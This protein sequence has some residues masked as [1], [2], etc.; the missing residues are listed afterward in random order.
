MH[1]AS[2]CAMMP[3]YLLHLLGREIGGAVRLAVV[4]VLL[5][6]LSQRAVIDTWT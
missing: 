5:G 6:P 3:K 4:R 2:R 1:V